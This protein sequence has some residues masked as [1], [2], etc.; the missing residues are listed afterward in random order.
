[1]SNAGVVVNYMRN[2]WDATEIKERVLRGPL[3]HA[4][5][6]TTR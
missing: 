2:V 1:V 4:L 5:L 3:P 6:R